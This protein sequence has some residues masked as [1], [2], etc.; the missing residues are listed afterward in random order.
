MHLVIISRAGPTASLAAREAIDTALA[1]A[2]FDQQVT[3][4][5]DGDG[6]YQLVK[7]QQPPAGAGLDAKLGGLSFF[8]VEDLR[9]VR[10]ALE[11]R[12]LEHSALV[13]GVAE[14]REG[15]LAAL[16][17]GADAVVSYA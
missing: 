9:V 5:F 11:T 1:A 4:L 2:A 12:G 15:D 13:A 7:A 16:L 3:L 6:V 10:R 17:A 8:E 14:V